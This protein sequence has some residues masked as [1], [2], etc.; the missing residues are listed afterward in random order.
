M[1]LRDDVLVDVAGGLLLRKGVTSVKKRMFA[2]LACVAAF[3]A[4]G[5]TAASAGEVNKPHGYIAGSDSA[6]LN[7]K[8]SCAFSGLNDNYVFGVAGPG[9]PDEDGFERVQNWGHVGQEGRAFLTSIGLN[10]GVACN[11]TKSEGGA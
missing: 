10:P 1:T 7:G 3:A 4:V 2:L 11:P 6:P 5:V 9:N 8:S